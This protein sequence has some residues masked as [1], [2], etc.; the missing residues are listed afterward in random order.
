MDTH[1]KI[2]NFVKLYDVKNGYLM[3]GYLIIFI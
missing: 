3:N 2:N 1:L